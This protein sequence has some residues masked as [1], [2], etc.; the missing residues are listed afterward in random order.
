MECGG[1]AERRRRFLWCPNA[2]QRSNSKA[3]Q[4][5]VALC[6]PPHSTGSAFVVYPT[7]FSV[8][9]G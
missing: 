6:L 2:P 3:V 1:G 8:S 4:S 9:Q 5:G 7:T